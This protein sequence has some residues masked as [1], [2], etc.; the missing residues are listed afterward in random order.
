VI[1]HRADGAIFAGINLHLNGLRLRFGYKDVF[2][3]EHFAIGAITVAALEIKG[4]DFTP[5]A[6]DAGKAPRHKA[7]SLAAFTASG[8]NQ[9]SVSGCLP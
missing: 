2:V 4:S 9:H 6:E 3:R 1:D 7:R 8:P 5:M